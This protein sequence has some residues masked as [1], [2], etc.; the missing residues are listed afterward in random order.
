MCNYETPVIM[1]MYN[2]RIN[3]YS[4]DTQPTKQPLQC[5]YA[6]YESAISVD[7]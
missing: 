6:T 5:R 7:T 3:R 2:L 4:G 1:L